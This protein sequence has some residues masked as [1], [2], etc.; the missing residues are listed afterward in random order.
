MALRRDKHEKYRC[1]ACKMHETVCICPLVPRFETRTRLVLVI[2]ELEARKTTNTGRIAAMGLPNHVVVTRGRETPTNLAA[3][4][5]GYRPLALYPHSHAAELSEALGAKSVSEIAKPARGDLAPIDPE[6]KVEPPRPPA[7]LPI[8][9]VVPD[10]NWR[11]ASKTYKRLLRPLNV[12]AVRLDAGTPGPAPDATRMRKGHME[13]GLS[14]LEAIGEAVAQIEGAPEIN[15][16]FR[17]IYKVM[18]ERTAWTKG[19]LPAAQVTGG[20]PKGVMPHAPWVLPDKPTEP[21]T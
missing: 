16:R 9:L 1:S 12:P 13:E 6:A 14:T 11:Q 17:Y 20:L 15:D 7:A 19:M 10:G 3:A 5:E 8:A 2:H 18:A 21:P 4:W